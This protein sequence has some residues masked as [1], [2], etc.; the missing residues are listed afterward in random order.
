MLTQVSPTSSAVIGTSMV[1]FPRART[2]WCHETCCDSLVTS[3]IESNSAP[4]T[5]RRAVSPGW[6]AFFSAMSSRYRSYP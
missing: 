3:T 4:R 5:S 2:T 1:S 6:T